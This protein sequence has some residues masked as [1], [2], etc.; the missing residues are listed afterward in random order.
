MWPRAGA[1]LANQTKSRRSPA[2]LQQHPFCTEVCEGRLVAGEG[3]GT[4]RGTNPEVR[5][6]RARLQT[7][8]SGS[9]MPIYR[10][11]RET[12]SAVS[13]CRIKWVN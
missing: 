5:Y 4:E 3:G 7:P 1:A 9:Q 2:A 10:F 6:R 11:Q 12:R 8:F 13:A